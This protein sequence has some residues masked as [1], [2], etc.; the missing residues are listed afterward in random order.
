L[1]GIGIEVLA[2]YRLGAEQQIVE[3]QRE[4]RLDLFDGPALG[5]LRTGGR[6]QMNDLGVQGY[7]RGARECAGTAKPPFSSKTGASCCSA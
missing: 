5:G 7:G 3:R 4:Q 1:N 6:R 2:M